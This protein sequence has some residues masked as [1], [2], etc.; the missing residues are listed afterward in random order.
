MA[1]SRSPPSPSATPPEFR[2]H[3]LNGSDFLDGQNH[4]EIVFHSDEV[5]LAEDGSLRGRGDL[6]IK[7]ITR[8]V[9]ATGSYQPVIEDAFGSLRTAIELNAT[10]DRRD[11]DMTWQMPLPDGGAADGRVALTGV[12]MAMVLARFSGGQVA[13]VARV[14]MAVA[15]EVRNVAMG[16]Y[17]LAFMLGGRSGRPRSWG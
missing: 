13:L 11:W 3:I 1:G 17:T 15:P 8:P 9:L 4:S 10:V 12:A 14:P 16:L 7:G 2:E 5:Q 6:T